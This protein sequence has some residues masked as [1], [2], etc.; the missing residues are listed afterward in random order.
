MDG[1]DTVP[2]EVQVGDHEVLWTAVAQLLKDQVSEAV[3]FST[4]HDVV[5]L[6]SDPSILRL[7]APNSPARGGIL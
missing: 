1:S 3:W 6:D 7:S 5:A 2:E 4:F